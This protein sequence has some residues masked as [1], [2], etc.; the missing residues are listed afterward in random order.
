MYALDLSLVIKS[1]AYTHWILS[2]V[3][4]VNVC[5]HWILALVIKSNAYIYWIL[6]LYIESNNEICNVIADLLALRHWK[7]SLVVMVITRDTLALSLVPSALVIKSMCSLVITITT[8]DIFQCLKANR[9][10][11]YQCIQGSKICVN[12]DLDRIVYKPWNVLD[13]QF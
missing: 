12:T 2:L 3:I 1:N 9:S 8:R 11:I 4:K 7:M 6:S 10:A 13:F 5:T